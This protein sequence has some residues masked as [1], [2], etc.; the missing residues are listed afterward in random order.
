MTYVV[1]TFMVH[2]TCNHVSEYWSINRLSSFLLLGSSGAREAA[3]MN[4]QGEDMDEVLHLR[5]VSTV[6]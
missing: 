5:G 1:F 4:S 2:P 3:M 6:C